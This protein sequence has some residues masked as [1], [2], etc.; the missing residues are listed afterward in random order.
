MHMI[1]HQAVPQQRD[2]V[3]VRILSQELKISDAIGVAGE[4]DLSRIPPLRNVMGNVDDHNARQP[5]HGKTITEV[6]RS[7]ARLWLE[8]GFSDSQI[9]RK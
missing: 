7:V 3:K 8:N 5:S 6:I 1:R 2:T 9:G 4:N